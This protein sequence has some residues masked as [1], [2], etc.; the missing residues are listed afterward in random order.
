MIAVSAKSKSLRSPGLRCAPSRLRDSLARHDARR[1]NRL[2]VLGAVAVD[3]GEVFVGDAAQLVA[4]G[5]GHAGVVDPRVLAHDR[6]DGVDVMG[7]QLSRYP[8]QI[9][10]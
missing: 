2:E 3:G 7:D 1:K 8:F 6:L 10:G 5:R 4:Q 9:R